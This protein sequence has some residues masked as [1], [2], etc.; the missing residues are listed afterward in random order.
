VRIL[1]DENLPE[2]LV[3]ALQQLGHHVDTIN[4]LRLKGLD[5]G[6]LYRKIAQAYDLC[7]TKDAGFVHN[8]RQMREPTKT[9]LLRVLL[10]QQLAQPF[11]NVFVLEFQRTDWSQYENGN[12]WP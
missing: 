10:P 8:I 11:V 3:S 6:T 1:L 9:K 2:S 5:N 12:D 4:S 7:F